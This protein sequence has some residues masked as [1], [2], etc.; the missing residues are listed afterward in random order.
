MPDVSHSN[1]DLNAAI[2]ELEAALGQARA[3][4]ERIRAAL[5]R[6]EHMSAVFAELESIIAAGRDGGSSPAVP[7]AAPSRTARPRS[8]HQTA[9]L[10]EIAA[11]AGLQPEAP[12][13]DDGLSLVEPVPDADVLD[14]LEPLVAADGDSLTS[15]RLEFQSERGTL[16]LRAVDDA[17]GEHPAVRDV[18]LIDYDGRR[19]VLKVWITGAARPAD[20]EQALRAR[21]DKIASD[22]GELS[23]VALEDAA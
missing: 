13:P 11:A 17:I 23:I 12:A 19:A 4:A 20:V 2:E 7:S 16:N 18:A 3:A 6:L 21:A 5:P 10:A 14:H 1:N 22:G 15:F 9:S 8:R